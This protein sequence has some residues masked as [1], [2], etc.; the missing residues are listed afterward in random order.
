MK[1]HAEKHID[2]TA[3]LIKRLLAGPARPGQ[4]FTMPGGNY[5]HLYRMARRVKAWF[6]DRMSADAPVCLF[7]DDRTVVAATLLATLAGGPLLLL[8]ERLTT[9]GMIDLHRLTGFEALVG[10]LDR[11]GID[12]VAAVDPYTLTEE[13]ET[14]VPGNPPDTDR[15]W[16]RLFTRSTAGD[17][18]LWTK[19]PGTL[20][21]EAAYLIDRFGFGSGDRILSAVAPQQFIGLLYSLLIP[22]AASARVADATPSDAKQIHQQASVMS[23][24]VFIGHPAHY[25]ALATDPADKGALRLA[26]ATDGALDKEAGQAF[27]KATGVDLVELYA[28]P[29]AGGIATRCRRNGD[30]GFRPYECIHARVSGEELDIRSPFLSAELPV[31]SSG[32]YTAGK[33]VKSIDGGGFVT[34]EQPR[35]PSTPAET[36]ENAIRFE[37]AG[38][39]VAC[40]DSQPIDELAAA[41]NIPIRTDCGG[42]GICAKCRILVHPQEAFSSPT[43]AELDVLTPDQMQAGVR[44]ACQARATGSATVRISDT[45][46]ER[47][48]TSGKIGIAR[49]YPADSP[50]RRVTATGR[51][52]ELSTDNQPASLLD[53]LTAQVGEPAAANAELA[54]L[55]QLSRYQ[56]SLKEFTLVVHADSGIRRILNGTQPTSLGFAVD[57]GTTSVAGYLCDLKSGALLAAD[58]CV[59]PQ[60][61][62]GEDVINRISRI[63]A[64]EALATQM[65]NLAVESI[66]LLLTRCMAA[67][68]AGTQDIDEMAVCGNTTMQQVLAGLHP[69]GLGAAPYFPLTPTPPA[70]SAGR[71]GLAVDAAVPVYFMPVISGF[72]GGDTMAAI[73]ADR[74]H[75]RDETTLIV[76]IGT[77][78]E[79]ALGNRKGLW[80]TSCA[81]GPALEGAQISCGMRA[82]AGAIHRARPDGDG[83]AFEVMGNA[84][85]RPMGICGSGIIDAVAAMRHLGIVL[86]N[87]RLNEAS[88]G[89]VVDDHGVGRH[90]IIAAGDRT[91]T[92]ND[93]VITLKDVRQIQ[94]AKGALS[95]GIE[96]LLRKAGIDHI[97]RTIL[98]GAFGAQFNWQNALSIGMLPPAVAKGRVSPKDNLAGVGVVMALLDK[99]AR[100][101]ARDL[102][103]RIRYLDLAADPAFAEAFAHATTF[104]DGAG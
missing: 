16:V 6:N 62:F 14:L 87:G 63:N 89:V 45:L 61:R 84:K 48:E 78:G 1:T 41:A 32:W 88:P 66:N 10:A 58:A 47:T 35:S 57:V 101:T 80:V 55:Q 94:L 49:S 27:V 95:T 40:T 34:A 59:N 56:E 12:G 19:T 8:P 21:G 20:L 44:L 71:L 97:D 4:A 28:S 30:A 65:Q 51:S 7:S 70:V 67:V 79:V 100:A 64:D 39:T 33:R 15:P 74:P 46:A 85:G 22:L 81:T 75:E 36:P 17:P 77:N 92:G 18:Q 53:W 104:P 5:D 26:F 52:P 42:L 2:P 13:V 102:C 31:R 83:I 91:A 73:L 90:Y 68:D 82:V 11:A 50:I 43:A 96:F 103:G 72:V 25:E 37:P 99:K 54:A 9:K 23:P 24:T 29:E 86:P 76:D 69:R 38:L 98:T 93:I 60:R 3:L